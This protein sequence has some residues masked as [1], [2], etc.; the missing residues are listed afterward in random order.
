[1]PNNGPSMV[2]PV[3]AGIGFLYLTLKL[4]SYLRLFFSLF[5]LSGRSVWDTIM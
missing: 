4:V 5:I 2:L 1:M 3:L